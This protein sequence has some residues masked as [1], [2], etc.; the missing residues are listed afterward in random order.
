MSSGQRK[1]ED[2]ASGCRALEKENRLRAVETP[3]AHMRASLERSADAWNVRAKLLERLETSF[4]E[5]AAKNLEIKP[6]RIT[7]ERHNG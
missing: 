5:R 6:R 1:P 2:S 3:N 4:N 7:A